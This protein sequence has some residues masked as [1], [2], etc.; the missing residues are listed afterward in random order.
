MQC[1]LSSAVRTHGEFCSR[2]QFCIQRRLL[3]LRQHP[4]VATTH[5]LL[6][7]T[8]QP[9]YTHTAAYVHRLRGHSV[10]AV[11]RKKH[12]DENGL[13]FGQSLQGTATQ[14]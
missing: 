7:L 14:R 4:S 13:E 10:T 5:T 2:V 11:L 3:Q 12:L 6:Q 9:M 1:V 8:Q